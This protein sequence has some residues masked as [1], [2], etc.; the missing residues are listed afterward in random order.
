MEEESLKCDLHNEKT[1]LIVCPL[2]LVKGDTVL[3]YE[4]LLVYFLPHS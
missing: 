1:Y 4:L 2:A 3:E